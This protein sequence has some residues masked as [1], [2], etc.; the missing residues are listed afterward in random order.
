MILT[1]EDAEQREY[2]LAAEHALSSD[3][4]AQESSTVNINSLGLTMLSEFA[5]A[6]AA[7]RATE[8][9]FIKDLRQFKGIY[10]PEVLKYIGAERSKAFFKATRV[11]VKTADARVTDLLFPSN[12][13][14]NFSVDST[15]K[16][17]LDIGN[18][19]KIAKLLI[20][21][22]GRN[23]TEQEMESAI[24]KVVKKTA[25]R[26]AQTI[27]DQLV[28]S[29]YKLTAKKVIH[30]GH[31]YGTGIL[32]APLVEVKT[33]IKYEVD[34][35]GKWVMKKQRYVAPFVD[36]VPVWRFYPDMNA[37]ELENCRYVFERHL[38]SQADMFKLAERK[39]FNG[40]AIKSYV[41]SNPNGIRKARFI[42]TE[43]K[44][45]GDISTK[46]ITDDGNYEVLERWGWLPGAIL[47]D[48]G[49]DVPDDRL[50]ETFFSNAW[51]LH[52]GEV[53]K[54]VLH[55]MDGV[56]WPYHLYYADKDETSI[57]AEGFASVMRD[58]QEMI[59]A[60]TRMVIDHAA[61]TAGG[62]YEAN[63]SLLSSTENADVI[64][65]FKVFKR[66]GAN[67]EIPAIRT[68]KIDSGLEELIP[69]INIFKENADD[70]TA[71]PRYMQGENAT[72]GAAGTA[73]GMSM[74]MASASIVMK[75]LVSNYDE[76]VTRT[77]VEALYRWNMQFNPDNSIK[78]DFDV[79]ALG[80][81]SLMAKEVR[82]QQLDNFSASAANPMDAP[83]IK[84]EVL[85]RQR[86]E[87][88]DLADIVK[89]EEEVQAEQNND[90]AKQQAQMQQQMQQM[91]MQQQM[92]AIQKM[93][94]DI[95]KT[96]ADVERI[97]A[98]AIKVATDTVKAKVD[99]AYAAMQAGGVAT[100]RP[101]IAPAGDAILHS[102]GWQ[103]ATP[104][105]NMQQEAAMPQNS[106]VPAEAQAQAD[107][108]IGGNSQGQDSN[109]LTP[110]SANVG[111]NIGERAGMRTSEVGDGAV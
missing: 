7:K 5:E 8:E 21:A 11:K 60:G 74:L 71:I 17:S 87:A 3:S 25:S 92:L 24:L 28:E 51:L 41:L 106:P 33:K 96:L 103:D 10:D 45:I 67:P 4:D 46:N 52:N 6:E 81:A 35:Q 69:I 66:N 63:M 105:T 12:S 9:R 47:R 94:A 91:Q 54:I 29:R 23:P 39:S 102:A 84:R 90:Q 57:F 64:H 34:E 20:E 76:G 31:L 62:M 100:E 61:M 70:V 14:R 44:A 50:H 79:K 73:S 111:A 77:F 26:M 1:K 42:D 104:E 98:D 88:H 37:T 59:N 82:A 49:V 86:A 18:K 108:M 83:Y 85:L 43:L 107:G 19:N 38:F 68:I 93:Q 16:P 30:S 80:T 27:D 36:F 75:D 97:R 78:G 110:P 65:P 101:D 53:I 99:T 58:D 13:E 89:T 15:P 72:Q 95:S 40:D 48:A 55:P 56:Q 32:K 2:E 22:L 109:P